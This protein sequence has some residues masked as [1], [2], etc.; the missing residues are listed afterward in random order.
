ML[1]ERFGLKEIRRHHVHDAWLRQ[2][3]EFAAATAAVALPLQR[4]IDMLPMVTSL[5]PCQ[6]AAVGD[7][8]AQH[9][10]QIEVSEHGV[11]PGAEEKQRSQSQGQV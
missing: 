8:K 10:R 4:Q 6:A 9:R 7:I 5:D 1:P 3:A 2:C 11:L